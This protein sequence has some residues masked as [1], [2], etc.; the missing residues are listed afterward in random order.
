MLKQ[1]KST[2]A[3]QFI[4]IFT[5]F[6]LCSTS[7]ILACSGF[8]IT[9]NDQVLIGHNKD[10]HNPQTTIHVYPAEEGSYARLFL[11]IPFPH[12]FDRDYNVLAGGINEHGL[13]YESFVTP[14]N[15]ASFELFKPPLFK[16]PVDYLLQKYTTVEEV[17]TYLESHNLFFLNYILSYGQIF[18]ADRSGDAA[19]IEGDEI[20][21]IQ[22]D[23]Q[24]CTNFLQSNPSLGNY[25]CWRYE[26][27]IESLENATTVNNSFVQS[28]LESV[29]LYAQYSWILDP[30]ELSLDLFHFHDFDQVI[31]LNLTEEFNQPKH[32]YFLPAMFEPDNN[33]APNKPQMPVGPSIGSINHDYH[34]ITNTTDE[35]N[36]HDAIYYQWDFGD[37]SQPFWEYTYQPYRGSTTHKWKK[38]GTYEV[39]VKSKDI[40]GKESPWSDP[41]QIEITWMN[42]M[43]LP[44]IFGLLG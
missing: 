8:T 30:I 19:I 43:V 7:P 23:Y 17:V 12:V 1:N 39:R 38:P 31:H 6:L 11:E 3:L 14:F 21:R 9:K 13:C 20:I 27:I 22:G 34:F 25:P 42:E 33:T 41:C 37:G 26:K 15:P 5:I 16:N 35:N 4:T 10:W 32:S 18:V 2:Y 36:D 24:A 40:Y 29:Q 44:S 28:L